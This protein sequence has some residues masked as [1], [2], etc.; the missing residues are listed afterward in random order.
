[1]R[2]KASSGHIDISSDPRADFPRSILTKVH[3]KPI[4]G[5]RRRIIFKL[6]SKTKLLIFRS[7]GPNGNNTTVEKSPLVW[8][9]FSCDC[10]HIFQP[11]ETEQMQ[12]LSL[13]ISVFSNLFWPWLSAALNILSKEGDKLGRHSHASWQIMFYN[14]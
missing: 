2:Q 3:Q 11:N 13:K 9:Y 14:N 4:S 12:I 5:L 7:A 1:M 8:I 6:I 10:F